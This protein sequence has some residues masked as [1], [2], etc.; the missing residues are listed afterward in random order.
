[1]GVASL[2]LGICS[3]VLAVFF[4]SAGWLAALLGLIGV[5]LGAVAN[6]K[7][8]TGVATAGVVLS[9]IGLVLGLLFYV[10]CIA[11]IGSLGGLSALD[12]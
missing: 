2:V 1:M 3:V 12:F 11:C 8:K 4:G 9:I 5:I 10:A 6:K 7:Q